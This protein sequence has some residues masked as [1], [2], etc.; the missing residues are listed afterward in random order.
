MYTIYGDI[1]ASK[2]KPF[3]AVSTRDFSIYE[4]FEKVRFIEEVKFCSC[5]HKQIMHDEEYETVNGYYFH[6]KD[7]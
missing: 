1:N 2:E 5:C 6:K 4:I 3:Y 7:C